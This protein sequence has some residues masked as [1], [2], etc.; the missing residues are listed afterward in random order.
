MATLKNKRK[1]AALNKENCEEHPRSNLAQNSN[2]CR[3][4][5]DYITQV[6]QEIEG[7]VTKTLSQELRRTKNRILGSLSR[8]NNFLLNPLIQGHSGTA[9]ETS[10]NAYGTNQGTN[11]DDSQSAS[12]PEAGIFQSQTTQNSGRENGHDSFQNVCDALKLP[13]KIPKIFRRKATPKTDVITA[14]VHFV[15]NSEKLKYLKTP[16]P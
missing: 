15:P 2:A 12:H 6:S 4:E 9:P 14:P 8:L 13:S 10:R 11:E 3:S 5:E 7:R 16:Q 1:L